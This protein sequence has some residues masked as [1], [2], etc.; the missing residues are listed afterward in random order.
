MLYYIKFFLLD[1]KE[2]LKKFRTVYNPLTTKKR[3]AEASPFFK[4]DLS[5][6]TLT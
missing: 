1:D 3:L 2:V 5:A 4:S 6:L